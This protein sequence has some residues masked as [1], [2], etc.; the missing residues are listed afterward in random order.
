[1]TDEDYAP[2]VNDLQDCTAKR[3]KVR[4]D[5]RL[6]YLPSVITLPENDLWIEWYYIIDLDHETFQVGSRGYMVE[7]RLRGLPGIEVWHKHLKGE[8]SEAGAG[9]EGD[10][11]K[12]GKEENEGKKKEEGHKDVVKEVEETDTDKGSDNRRLPGD[13]T[14]DHSL[15]AA[16]KELKITQV[17]AKHTID[18]DSDYSHDHI[19]RAILFAHFWTF[20]DIPRLA[21]ELDWRTFDFGFRE[22]AFAIICLASGTFGLQ[23]QPDLLGHLDEGYCWKAK[24]S[25]VHQILSAFAKGYHAPGMKPGS[26]P[27]NTIYWFKSVVICLDESVEL[28]DD[29]QVAIARAVDFGRC[30]GQSM[31][32]GLVVSLTN[33]VLFRYDL[34]TGVKFSARIPY[35]AAE[36]PPSPPPEPASN[37]AQAL[38]MIGNEDKQKKHKAEHPFTKKVNSAGFNAMIRLFDGAATQRLK[39]FPTNTEKL[40]LEICHMILELVDDTTYQN[41]SSVSRSFR[42]Y[43][44]KNLR[45]GG[46]VIRKYLAPS[47]F[48]ISDTVRGTDI[49]ST[50]E[51]VCY[52]HDSDHMAKVST[53]TWFPVLADLSSRSRLT[54][55]ENNGLLFRGLTPPP[56]PIT[57]HPRTHLL[58]NRELTDPYMFGDPGHSLGRFTTA[59]QTCD[60]WDRLLGRVCGFGQNCEVRP[61]VHLFKLPR[62]TH[63]ISVHKLARGPSSKSKVAA[64]LWVRKPADLKVK[65]RYELALRDAREHLQRDYAEDE[66]LVGLVFGHWVRYFD[67]VVKGEGE[68]EAR[69]VDRNG[70]KMF[71]VAD[72]KERVKALKV[73]QDIAESA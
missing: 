59:R 13:G 55:L 49:S 44:Q 26:A 72:D 45:L 24:P 10:E 2:D 7:Y 3:W 14:L 8:G 53:P 66:V 68:G 62:N 1:M 54:I 47:T 37:F 56:L 22:V 11:D 38:S 20:Y 41:C 32:D 65:G 31:F 51:S 27:N 23:A 40:P 48:E 29:Y 19:L 9:D 58:R 73:F 36:Q 69:L 67:W 42:A 25:D 43:T 28:N 12:E 17:V 16:Y 46:H 50:P 30:A 4:L 57:P 71:K 15:L 33:V 21:E 63:V 18:L 6:E 5:E 70:G 39:P 52:S 60:A 64:V 35:T 61:E 34:K